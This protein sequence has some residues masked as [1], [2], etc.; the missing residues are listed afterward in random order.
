MSRSTGN[1]GRRTTARRDPRAEEDAQP[2]LSIDTEGIGVVEEVVV[3]RRDPRAEAEPEAP[4]KAPVTAAESAPEEPDSPAEPTPAEAPAAQPIDV[5]SVESPSAEAPSIAL[6]SKS[7]EAEKSD[8]NDVAEASG[9]S[10]PPPASPA[11]TEGEAPESASLPPSSLYMAGDPRFREIDPLLG[12]NAWQ[13]IVDRLT[14][15]RDAGELPPGLGLILAL[16]ERELA[17]EGS[18]AAA[19]AHAIESFAALLGVSARSD[20]ALIL[21]KRLLRQPPAGWR[22]Q[23]TPP[24]RVSVPIIVIG[25][26]LGV[27]AGWFASLGSFRFF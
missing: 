7:T 19:N 13:E 14:A 15:S 2:T 4:V 9:A 27:A 18:A 17:G 3:A 1:S 11:S 21:A 6:T 26:A 12:R 20:T 8:H 22:T 24:A 16:A 23:A 10:E 25:I 5:P